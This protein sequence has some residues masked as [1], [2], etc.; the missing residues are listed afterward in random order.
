MGTIWGT[1]GNGKVS[2]ATHRSLTVG[3][4]VQLQV[5]QDS[6]AATYEEVAIRPTPMAHLVGGAWVDARAATWSQVVEV[7]SASVRGVAT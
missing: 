4:Y 1:I 5:L 6:L 7:R 3:D 2:V